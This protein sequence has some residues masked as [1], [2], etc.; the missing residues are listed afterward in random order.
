ME[1]SLST[2]KEA[3]LDPATLDVLFGDARTANA[4]TDQEV[5]AEQART[6]YELTKFGPTAFNNQP[7]RITY[8][9]KGPGRER[10]VS[11]L[12]ENN[13][14]KALDAPLVAVLAFD[15]NWHKQIPMIFPPKPNLGE[16]FEANV[17]ARHTLGNNNAHLQAGYFIMA[18]RALG[19][20]AGP[21][22]GFNADTL[23]ADFFPIGER[24]A[25]MVVNIGH[26]AK[27]AWHDTRLPRLPYDQ[28][29]TV[30]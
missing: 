22:G 4:F 12:N 26:P 25:F 28:A 24:R 2:P 23:N 11:H 1:T 29:V 16:S 30:L 8:T 20:A 6:I 19:L 3:G 10:L 5:T 7:L 15:T 18:V 21:M 17:A 9:Y 14:Q 13:K 27:N